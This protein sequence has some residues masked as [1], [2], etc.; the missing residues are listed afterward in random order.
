MCVQYYVHTSHTVP[1]DLSLPQCLQV[2][3]PSTASALMDLLRN[4]SPLKAEL[5]SLLVTIVILATTLVSGPGSL[6]VGAFVLC[7]DLV[8]ESLGLFTPVIALTLDRYPVCW[9]VVL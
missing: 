9:K 3:D 6:F 8:C 2:Q 1:T 5:L 7:K 4:R